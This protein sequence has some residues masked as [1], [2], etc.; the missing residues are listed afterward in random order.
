MQVLGNRAWSIVDLVMLLRILLCWLNAKA[1]ARMA[2][3]KAINPT[4][5]AMRE[6][7]KDKPQQMQQQMLRSSRKKKVNPMGGC[8]PS[9]TRILVFIALY[10]VLQSSVE[11]RHAP[12]TRQA[13]MM[14]IMPLASGVVF[15]FPA[16]GLPA[17]VSSRR[18]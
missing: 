8:F 9:L 3:I 11:I 12:W 13:K 16:V 4:N 10:R 5:A 6:R 1:Y 18:P 17:R 2:Q 14:C 7:L 15:F